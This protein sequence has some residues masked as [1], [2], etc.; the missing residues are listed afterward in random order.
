MKLKID[1]TELDEF[2]RKLE[3]LDG[4]HQVKIS[5]LFTDEFVQLNLGFSNLEDLLAAA[6]IGEDDELD[7]PAFSEFVARN[8][9]FDDYEDMLDTAAGEWA[10]RQLQ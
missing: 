3:S 6:G 7:T 2:R 5:E 8:S 4:G 10:E 9:S 1:T